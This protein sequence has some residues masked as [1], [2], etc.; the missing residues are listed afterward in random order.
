[1]KYGTVDELVKYLKEKPK[2]VLWIPQFKPLEA[3]ASFV[4]KHP[5]RKYDHVIGDVSE[6]TGGD[7]RIAGRRENDGLAEDYN[8]GI[9]EARE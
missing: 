7:V 1:M 4:S 6:I 8:V 5:G 9:N 3:R 2:Q